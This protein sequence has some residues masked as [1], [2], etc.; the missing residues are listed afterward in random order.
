MNCSA[1][2]LRLS[3]HQGRRQRCC[4]GSLAVCVASD[5]VIQRYDGDHGQSREQHTHHKHPAGT[6]SSPLRGTGT[7]HT[8]THTHN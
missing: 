5:A 6:A 7:G 3:V 2:G 8:D 4:R 1:D